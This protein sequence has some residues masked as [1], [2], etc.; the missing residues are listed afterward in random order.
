[1]KQGGTLPARKRNARSMK[2]DET[3]WDN[4]GRDGTTWDEMGRRKTVWDDKR[5]HRTSMKSPMFFGL[6]KREP[7]DFKQQH[8][9]F[10]TSNNNPTKSDYER[11]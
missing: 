4:V 2:P 3:E 10:N 5:Q 7:Q 1:M 6:Q 9:K 8:F 11:L